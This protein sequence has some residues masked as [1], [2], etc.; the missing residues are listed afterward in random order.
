MLQSL[1]PLPSIFVSILTGQGPN[2]GYQHGQETFMPTIPPLRP[3]TETDNHFIQE[4]VLVLLM[5][6]KDGGLAE[7]YA[8][9]SARTRRLGNYIGST[10]VQ[11]DV[12]PTTLCFLNMYC[13]RHHLCICQ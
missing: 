6:G 10:P 5:L 12:P 4:R 2:F 1:H 8:M 13:Q 3:P 7:M 9:L 11:I